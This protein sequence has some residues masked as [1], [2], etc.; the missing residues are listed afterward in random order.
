MPEKPFKA[1]LMKSAVLLGAIQLAN[2]RLDLGTTVLNP[3]AVL[4][5]NRRQSAWDPGASRAAADSRFGGLRY[6]D[7]SRKPDGAVENLRVQ[8]RFQIV[9]ALPGLDDPLTRDRRVA[10]LDMARI[11]PWDDVCSQEFYH[12]DPNNPNITLQWRRS[13]TSIEITVDDPSASSPL[14]IGPIPRNGRIYGARS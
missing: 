7:G 10:L 9:R 4:T 2:E 14:K 13:E 5:D 11:P 1:D 3:L 12:K 8:G 6:L